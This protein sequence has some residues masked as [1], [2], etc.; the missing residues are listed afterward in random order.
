MHVYYWFS[1]LFYS[2][3]DYLFLRF[4]CHKRYFYL[5]LRQGVSNGGWYANLRPS[6]WDCFFYGRC[7]GRD[8]RSQ[9]G[10]NF[11]LHAVM[12]ALAVCLAGSA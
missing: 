11:Y 3:N 1:F 10:K 4:K 5:Y 9:D 12:P 8:L 2:V 7:C 6:C